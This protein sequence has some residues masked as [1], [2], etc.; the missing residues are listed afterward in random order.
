MNIQLV[1]ICGRKGSGKDTVADF[2]SRRYGFEKRALAQPIKH[3]C[4]YLFN[5]NEAQLDGPLKEAIDP[6]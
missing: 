6:Q 5:F 2:I 4:G 3:I 1:G